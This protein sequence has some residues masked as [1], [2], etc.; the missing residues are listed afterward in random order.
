LSEEEAARIL[1][2]AVDRRSLAPDFSLEFDHLGTCTVGE[3]LADPER[4]LA[5]P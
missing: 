4:L 3:V 2:E 1:A 5:R